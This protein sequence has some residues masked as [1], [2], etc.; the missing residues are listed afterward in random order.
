[1]IGDPYA[2][3]LC[4]CDRPLCPRCGRNKIFRPISSHYDEK[5]NLLWHVPDFGGLIPCDECKERE[6]EHPFQSSSSN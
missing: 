3:V 5:G 2:K 6:S 4:L 1:L